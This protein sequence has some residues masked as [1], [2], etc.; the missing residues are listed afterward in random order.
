[1]WDSVK[2][3]EQVQVDVSSSFIHQHCNPINVNYYG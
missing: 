1:M 2:Y 3:I